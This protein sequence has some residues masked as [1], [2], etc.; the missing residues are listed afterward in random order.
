MKIKYSILF[1]LISTFITNAQK[2]LTIE[3]KTYTNSDDTWLGVNIPRDEPTQFIFRNNSISSI[4]RYGYLLQAGDESKKSTNNNLD[5]AVITGN[6]FNW[7]G[8]DMKVIPHGLFAGHNSNVVAKYNYL[9][10]VPMGIIRKSTT[11]MSN[12]GGG[13]AY[14]IVKNGAVGI[15]V[16]GMSNVNIFNNT[17]Y[18][19]RT[20]TQTWRPLLHIYTNIDA[21]GYSVAHGT[22]IYNNIFYTKYETFAITVDDTESLKGLECD[23]NV[24]W[25]ESGSPRFYIAGSVKSF[26]QWQ[27]MGYDQHSV[28]INPQFT[29]LI[30]FV[31]SKRL[32]YGKDLGAEWADG[33][34]TTAKW[35]TTAP[36]TAAQNGAWQAG[37]VVYAGQVVTPPPVDAGSPLYVSSGIE[38]AT[39]SKIDLTFSLDLTNKIPAAAAFTAKVNNTAKAVQTVTVAGTKVSLILSSALRN[40]DVVTI[41]YTKP[42]TNPLQSAAGGTVE[43]FTDKPVTNNVLKTAEVP[44]DTT[45]LSDVNR[46]I[47]IFPNPASEYINIENI[48]SSQDPRTVRIFTF[49]G[50]LCKEVKLE[51]GDKTTIPIDLSSGMYFVQVEIGSVIRHTQKLL[52][53]E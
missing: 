42:A 4:N 24:Y 46:K 26:A 43:S 14:N 35:G 40:E 28:V 45:D 36:A 21:G 23:Y 9:N 38:N 50:R 8:S 15:V 22:K 5:G 52:I 1:I 27:A 3:G 17:L 48:E 53:V 37:A 19:D 49:T 25:C 30:S 29:D 10:N 39:P 2:S 47:T 51:A 7:S 31:P 20:P 18:T 16:K 11:N 34:A 32:D 33:L 12:T 44:A 6:K 13:V 41:S